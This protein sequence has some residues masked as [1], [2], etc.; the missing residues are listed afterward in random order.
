MRDLAAIHNM[1]LA[2]C[3][4]G[5]DTLGISLADLHNLAETA[6]ADYRGQFEIVNGEWAAL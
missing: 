3:L 2:Y 6:F 5:V 4:Q 1:C